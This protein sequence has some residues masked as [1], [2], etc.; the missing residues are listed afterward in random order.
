MLTGAE[1]EINS[2]RFL[3]GS[4]IGRIDLAI[5]IKRE[6]VVLIIIAAARDVEAHAIGAGFGHVDFLADDHAAFQFRNRVA[7]G[8]AMAVI[9]LQDL[10]FSGA[11]ID[12]A[13][14]QAAPGIAAVI[15]GVMLEIAID[16]QVRAL[17]DHNRTVAVQAIAIQ[18]T[19]DPAGNRTH[20][21][22]L[23]QFQLV[24]AGKFAAFA[25]APDGDFVT[26]GQINIV[27]GDFAEAGIGDT[28]AAIILVQLD[29]AGNI[30]AVH[31]DIDQAFAV[32]FV[33]DAQGQIPFAIGTIECGLGRGPAIDLALDD[34][35]ARCRVIILGLVPA[36]LHVFGFDGD[37]GDRA[38]R[39]HARIDIGDNAAG[40]EADHLGQAGGIR[41]A[42]EMLIN[43][44]ILGREFQ[45]GFRRETHLVIPG[46]HVEHVIAI[47]IGNGGRDNRARG[48][49]QFDRRP[50]NARIPCAGRVIPLIVIAIFVFG[51]TA[52]DPAGLR[53]VL[54]LDPQRLGLAC[55][56]G[57]GD[58]HGHVIG[59]GI[60]ARIRVLEIRSLDE[61]QFAGG[62]VDFEKGRIPAA[63]DFVGQAI[64]FGIGI[65]RAVNVDDKGGVLVNTEN[66]VLGQV[67]EDRRL[68]RGNF[69]A[70]AEALEINPGAFDIA[71]RGDTELDAR[72]RN[73]TIEG[74]I[75]IARTRRIMTLDLDLDHV[76]GLAIRALQHVIAL[77]IHLR[78]QGGAIDGR[79]LAGAVIGVFVA[80][81]V[82]RQGAVIVPCGNAHRGRPGHGECVATTDRRTIAAL[83]QK[84]GFGKCCELILLICHL[85]RSSSASNAAPFAAALTQFPIDMI[86]TDATAA[87]SL[88]RGGCGLKGI[89]NRKNRSSS[90]TLTGRLKRY[91]EDKPQIFP[92]HYTRPLG[93]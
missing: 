60:A 66:A 1:I 76:I 34:A 64:A 38:I 13:R 15:Q 20:L 85:L 82:A 8:I 79:L 2:D 56:I 65:V 88:G 71:G 90:S 12:P 49:D 80:I 86:V 70:S 22:F 83:T 29:R 61:A 50:G 53:H 32:I 21:V 14:A 59:V 43:A 69:F 73:R 74:E 25:I 4:G 17:L 10:Y 81:A 5:H 30:D 72:R 36:K 18:I 78:A 48:I 75:I 37:A 6:C 54:D 42:V 87:A 63:N 77:G 7:G 28:I 24:E 35:I 84:V 93:T 92:T 40:G 51:E 27:Q 23:A 41:I 62:I 47:G 31:I 26:G 45:T 39:F 11:D 44:G 91:E 3:T 46:G 19:E 68:V 67:G 33:D 16:D 52:L 58:F 9:L 89:L 55:A 57:I